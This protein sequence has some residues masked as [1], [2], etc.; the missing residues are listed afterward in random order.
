MVCSDQVIETM[1]MEDE[2]FLKDCKNLDELL[3]SVPEELQE[4]FEKMREMKSAEI[5]ERISDYKKVHEG[6]VLACLV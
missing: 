3:D 4:E 2:N 1:V 6:K 5:S